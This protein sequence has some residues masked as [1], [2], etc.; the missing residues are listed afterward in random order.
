MRNLL[1]MKNLLVMRNLLITLLLFIGIFAKAQTIPLYIGV[2]TCDVVPISEYDMPEDA[3]WTYTTQVLYDSIPFLD[4]RTITTIRYKVTNYELSYKT[5]IR[6]CMKDT[7]KKALRKL[8][9]VN[10][11]VYVGQ[12]TIAG[13]YMTIQLQKPFQHEAGRNLIVQIETYKSSYI[14]FEGASRGPSIGAD[15]NKVKEINFSPRTEFF[16]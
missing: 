8:E 14:V 3:T 2:A 11:E 5:F 7:K 15:T 6:I 1:V 4:D 9:E 10:K 13:D 12:A 16:Y